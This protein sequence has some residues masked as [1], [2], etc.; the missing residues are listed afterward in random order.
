MKALMS[1]NLRSRLFW[2][3]AVRRANIPNDWAAFSAKERTNSPS[4]T[5]S[6]RAAQWKPASAGNDASPR[7]MPVAPERFPISDGE[8]PM[9]IDRDVIIMMKQENSG[10]ENGRQENSDR[11]LIVLFCCLSFSCP[12]FS[13]PP[14]SCPS[15]SCP[16]FSCLSFSCPPFSCLSFSCPPF[17]YLLYFMEAH[18]C[19]FK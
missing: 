11:V 10:Q 12:P 4:S 2:A 15:F 19:Q 14:F 7:R 16:S 6:Q 8:I 17:S 3:G 13:C 5:R 18:L 9:N 1:R